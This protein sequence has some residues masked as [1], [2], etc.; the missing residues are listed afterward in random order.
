[1]RVHFLLVVT[2]LLLI[3]GC[4]GSPSRPT[5]PVVA[6]GPPP[7]GA[8]DLQLSSIGQPALD[9]AIV[10][11]DQGLANKTSDARVYPTV[12]KAESLLLPIRLSQAL[13]ESGAWGV[14]RVVHSAETSLALV[15]ET[16]ILRADGADLHLSVQVKTAANVVLMQ[17]EYRDTAEPVDYPVKPGS[18]PFDDIYYAIANDL[19]TA[20][21]ALSAG[22]KATLQKL[23][24]MRFAADLS[25]SAF[26]RFLAREAD[27]YALRS[28]PADGDPMLRRLDRLR[29]QDDLFVDSVDQRYR[30]LYEEVRESYALWREYS[31]ELQRFGQSYRSSAAERKRTGR[32]GSYAAMQQVYTSFRKVKIQEED[33]GDI[34]DGF[35]GD[36]LETVLEV[37]DGVFRLSG[38]VDERYEEWR[39]ILGRIYDLETGELD[40]TAP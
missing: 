12:R 24:L 21:S 18:D 35:A 39:R 20:V 13:Q 19:R 37:D 1:M 32:R 33:L 11:F 5:E 15:L 26:S 17:K 36:S 6:N 38:S 2:L 7:V 34:V 8:R 25:P 31:F 16:E 22:E 10:V 4:T 9:V 30:D 40:P 27:S 14:V 23:A 29:R 28:Y 3:A